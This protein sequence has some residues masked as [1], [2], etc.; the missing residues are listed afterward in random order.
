MKT[1]FAAIA[2][3]LVGSAV[4]VP[5]QERQ[6]RSHPYSINDIS[7]KHLI[8]GDSWDFTFTINHLSPGGQIVESTSAHTAWVNNTLPVGPANPEAAENPDYTYYFPTGAF[9]V[10]EKFNFAIQ[11]PGGL[12]AADIEA[13]NKYQCVKLNSGNVDVECKTINGGAFV[14]GAH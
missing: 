7:I 12:A 1:S 6:I 9:H 10:E 5:V 13:G 2:L 14:F 4:A 11:G 3:A 8:E